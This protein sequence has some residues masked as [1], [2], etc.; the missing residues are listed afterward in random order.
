MVSSKNLKQDPSL[1]KRSNCFKYFQAFACNFRQ[2]FRNILDFDEKLEK[3][4]LW[5]HFGTILPKKPK[6]ILCQNKKNWLYVNSFLLTKFPQP[7]LS[8][9]LFNCS[10]Q[11]RITIKTH[12]T[13]PHWDTNK[14]TKCL[15]SPLKTLKK[16]A[17]FT[18]NSYPLRYGVQ[19]ATFSQIYFINY[20]L[21]FFLIFLRP[22]YKKVVK[23]VYSYWLVLIKDILL[24]LSDVIF[25]LFLSKRSC[26]YLILTGN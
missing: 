15:L 19:R 26:R 22:L 3:T 5:D 1:Q 16:E 24:S 20:S 10:L 17:G 11:G 14:P 25:L 6:Q 8:P 7:N 2:K 12:S 9:K 4:L 23:D 18:W 21:N 13:I